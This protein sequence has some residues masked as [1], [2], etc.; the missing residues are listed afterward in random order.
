MSVTLQDLEKEVNVLILEDP[1]MTEKDCHRRDAL[2]KKCREHAE[3]ASNNG[4]RFHELSAVHIDEFPAVDYVIGLFDKQG[5]PTGEYLG[6]VIADHER[7]LP[8]LKRFTRG[9]YITGDSTPTEL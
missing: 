8:A 5:K 1:W 4:F 9:G 7:A 2:V 6:Y 3:Q